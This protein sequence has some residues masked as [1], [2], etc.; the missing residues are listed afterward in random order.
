M[1]INKKIL[2]LGCG[3]MGSAMAKNLIKNGMEPDLISAISPSL[4]QNIPGI[5][6]YRS[7]SE[8]PQ[9][10]IADFVFIAVKPQNAKEILEDFATAPN[11]SK[12]TVFISILAGKKINFFKEILG[13]SAKII[14]SMPNLPIV[15]NQG[16]F[17]YI[18]SKNIKEKQRKNSTE[19]FRNFGEIIELKNEKLF[20]DFTAIFGSGPAYIFLLQEVFYKIAE[21]LKIGDEKSANLVKKLFLGSSLMSQNSSLNFSQLRESVTSKNGT[22]QSGLEVLKKNDSLEKLFQKTIKAASKR[23]KTL[24]K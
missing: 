18:F 19:L 16:I 17:A 14:R 4:N 8:L 11:F 24:S 12:N 21:S 13:K 3:K 1:I 23:S 7:A 5:K 6:Y 10:Y 20:D 22:T 2:F 15:E 9:N